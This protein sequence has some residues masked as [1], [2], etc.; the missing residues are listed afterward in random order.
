MILD[1][2]SWKSGVEENLC[3]LR[4]ARRQGEA[5][6]RGNL[7]QYVANR[8]KAFEALNA[9]DP[10]A[11]NTQDAKRRLELAQ[12]DLVEANLAAAE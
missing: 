3:I 8:L 7:M 6:A 2:P 12:R 4:E 10:D 1:P 9:L 11:Q 5:A